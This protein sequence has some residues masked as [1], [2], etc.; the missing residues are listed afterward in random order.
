MIT[1]II[2]LI[3]EPYASRHQSYLY[4]RLILHYVIDKAQDCPES[5]QIMAKL[6]GKNQYLRKITSISEVGSLC[7]VKHRGNIMYREE[8]T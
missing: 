6:A 3:L 4:F 8:S 7:C 5:K 1:S 2:D